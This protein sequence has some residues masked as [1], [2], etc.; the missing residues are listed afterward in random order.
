MG[1]DTIPNLHSY[2]FV[3]NQAKQSVEAFFYVVSSCSQ[4]V[5]TKGI[6]SDDDD[7]DDDDNENNLL[8]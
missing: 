2:K 5:P 6:K 3:G 4:G 7:D 8:I 1:H